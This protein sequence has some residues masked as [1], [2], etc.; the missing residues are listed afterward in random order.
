MR[1]SLAFFGGGASSLEGDTELLPKAKSSRFPRTSQDSGPQRHPRHLSFS[2]IPH[3]VSQRILSAV[4]SKTVLKLTTSHLA[5]DTSLRNGV[6]TFVLSSYSQFESMIAPQFHWKLP[7]G[8]DIILSS[9]SDIFKAISLTAHT[10]VLSSLCLPP[11]HSLSQTL[12]WPRWPLLLLKHTVHIPTS[13][14]LHRLF[15]LPETLFHHIA[16]LPY[17]LQMSNQMPPSQWDFFWPRYFILQHPLP[18][19]PVFTPSYFFP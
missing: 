1:R 3:S 4:P 14:P 2:N 15:L 13:G 19:S 7:C 17:F 10:T 9:C 18:A 12:L 6:P 11:C 8:F 5:Y 16:K